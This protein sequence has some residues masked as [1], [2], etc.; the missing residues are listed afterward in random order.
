MLYRWMIKEGSDATLS[1]LISHLLAIEYVFGKFLN[2]CPDMN[3]CC[4]IHLH[5][6]KVE[7]SPASQCAIVIVNV[8]YQ[9]KRLG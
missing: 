1:A 8:N 9:A 3:L 4:K 7:F 5:R 2:F 6:G